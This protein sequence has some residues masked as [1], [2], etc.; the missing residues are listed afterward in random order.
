MREVQKDVSARLNHGALQN[1]DDLARFQALIDHLVAKVATNAADRDPKVTLAQYDCLDPYAVVVLE[2]LPEHLRHNEYA[3]PDDASR[4]RFL[5]TLLAL[6]GWAL[7]EI[8]Q[9]YQQVGKRTFQKANGVVRGFEQLL[10][11]AFSL[12]MSNQSDR[13]LAL[14]FQTSQQDIAQEYLGLILAEVKDLR[15]NVREDIVVAVADPFREMGDRIDRL[16]RL[17]V[18]ENKL[19][20]DMSI[21]PDFGCFVQSFH[22]EELRAHEATGLETLHYQRRYD[23]LLGRSQVLEDLLDNFLDGVVDKTTENLFR[24][25][26]IYGD[27]GTGKNRLALDLLLKAEELYRKAFDGVEPEFFGFIDREHSCDDDGI[28]LDTIAHWMPGSPSILVIDYAGSLPKITRAISE[29]DACARRS[30]QP[31]RLILLDRKTTGS[32]SDLTLQTDATQTHVTTRFETSVQ[33]YHSNAGI[34]LDGLRRE[35]AIA[36]IRNRLGVRSEDFSDSYLMARLESIRP[37]SDITEDRRYT[38]RP[39]FAAMV[40]EFLSARSLADDAQDDEELKVLDDCEKILDQIIIRERL[41]FWKRRAEELCAVERDVEALLERHENLLAMSTFCRGLPL[42]SAQ[43]LSSNG[44]TPLPSNDFETSLFDVMATG[45]RRSRERGSPRAMGTR[46]LGFV[47]PD[48]IGEWFVLS[49]LSFPDPDGQDRHLSQGRRLLDPQEFI[50]LCWDEGDDRLVQFVLRCYQ[51]H[52]DRV[53]ELDY[54]LPSPGKH[55]AKAVSLIRSIFDELRVEFDAACKDE[56]G[57]PQVGLE[58][59]SIAEWAS[60]LFDILREHIKGQDLTNVA[61][62]LLV[63]TAHHVHFST[64]LSSKQVRARA[65]GGR[66][67]T[68]AGSVHRRKRSILERSKKII[69]VRLGRRALLQGDNAESEASS[70]FF[71]AAEASVL[72]DAND[73]TR[74]VKNSIIAD[75]A[76]PI[77]TFQDKAQRSFSSRSP[78]AQLRA[79]LVGQTRQLPENSVAV[80]AAKLMKDAAAFFRQLAD[81]ND[82]LREQMVENATVYDQV[83]DLVRTDPTGALSGDDGT[84]ASH[85]SLAS[86]L[87]EDAANFFDA[88]GEANEPL[89]EQMAENA[90]VFRQMAQVLTKD[91]FEVLG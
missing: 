73:G 59:P 19:S 20:S 40:G 23:D 84:S 77:S 36:L 15:S 85:V 45:M 11:D 63:I 80:L 65:T 37:D 16:F 18:D 33:A 86:K 1:S 88:L 52:P 70:A 46:R 34:R 69:K 60:R 17:F 26:L 53:Q 14:S 62:D 50:D 55:I 8:P 12:R 82:E 57:L 29:L 64:W 9:V 68:T 74:R 51:N 31:I 89:A 48:L 58:Q 91:P 41:H 71:A 3:T 78:A 76:D 24:W 56:Q 43:A 22:R 39:L 87:L 72:E 6:T 49:L 2:K 44:S 30:K 66:V 38:F 4:T 32:L 83:S 10:L 79:S 21:A 75:V 61:E 47:E 27:A 54:L 35:D 42:T 25:T 13:S 67:S 7:T 90:M 5:D 28:R 81:D